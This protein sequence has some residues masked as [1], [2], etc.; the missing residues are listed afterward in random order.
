MI[1]TAVAVLTVSPALAQTPASPPI[2]PAASGANL[3]GIWKAASPSASLKPVSGPIP[4]TDA[5]RKLYERNKGL[6][7][8]KDY[9]AYDIA[10]SRCST[11]GIPRLM[12]TGQRFKLWQQQGVVTFDFEWN[13]AIRQIDARG[14]PTEAPAVP[15]MTGVSKGHWEG[16]TLVALTT[17][18]SE[19]T[20]I[21]DLVPHTIDMKVTERLRLLDANTLEDRVT[22]ED[23]TLFTKPWEAVITYK[24]QPDAAFPEDVCMDRLEKHQPAFPQS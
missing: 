19:R 9:D 12:L 16:D 3:E 4:F 14:A 24:R 5:G 2:Q 21:D 7:A 15:N 13:R 22:I 11:P 10:T 17:D 1:A 6:K 23:P 20:L 18:V 8:R